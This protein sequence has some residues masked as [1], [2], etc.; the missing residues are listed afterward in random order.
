MNVNTFIGSLPR[1]V[2]KKV[3]KVIDENGNVIQGVGATDNLKSTA[4][5]YINDKY[6]GRNL[7]LVFSHYNGFITIR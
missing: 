3:W 1:I 5:K 2:Q 6:V 4:Q 7:T